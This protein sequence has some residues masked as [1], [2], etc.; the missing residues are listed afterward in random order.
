M[1]Q[2]I[3]CDVCK[4]GWNSKYKLEYVHKKKHCNECSH[5]K[6]YIKTYYLCSDKCLKK[7]IDK[8]AGH[9]CDMEILYMSKDIIKN[10]KNIQ[11]EYY[12]PICHIKKYK[13]PTKKDIEEY[14]R[15]NEHN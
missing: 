8:F 1:M 3:V 14:F 13:K 11:V 7:F 2:I 4:K 12:C 10:Y 5:T 9:K 15:K 6:E